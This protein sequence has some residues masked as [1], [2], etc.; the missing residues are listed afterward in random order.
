MEK[1]STNGK[2]SCA[3]LRLAWRVHW[4]VIVRIAVNMKNR[5]L[6]IARVVKNV[7]SSEWLEK[8]SWIVV[9]LIYPLPTT[10]SIFLSSYVVAP[11]D[12][13]RLRLKP[14]IPFFF[15]LS[16]D[17]VSSCWTSISLNRCRHL[18]F[19][20]SFSWSS[21]LLCASCSLTFCFLSFVYSFTFVYYLKPKS[22][23]SRHGF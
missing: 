15:C 2:D 7:C 18:I 14:L 4:R 9:R 3:A 13:F 19:W 21:T 11:R 5:D 6:N 23:P 20:P 16:L 1:K 17:L 12:G 22:P 10:V 8:R